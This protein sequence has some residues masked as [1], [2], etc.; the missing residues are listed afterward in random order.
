MDKTIY[1]SGPIM[2]GGKSGEEDTIKNVQRG[3]DIYGKLI[4]LGYAPYC[5]HMSYYP[6]KR[7][8]ESGERDINHSDW[9]NLDSM[10][11]EKCA[12]FFY[13]KPEYY[14]PSKGA[15][16]ELGWAKEQGK[17]IYTDIDKVPDATSV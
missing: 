13:M 12:Y 10:W 15:S 6:D 4:E 2:N 16:I 7:W 5:P 11:V 8:R 1:I 14:G 17:V 3:E 9:L